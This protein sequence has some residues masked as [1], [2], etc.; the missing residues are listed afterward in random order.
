MKKNAERARSQLCAQIRQLSAFLDHLDTLKKTRAVVVSNAL[1]LA[2][3]D[4]CPLV[5]S[6]YEGSCKSGTGLATAISQ[7]L[8]K[9]GAFKQA[10]AQGESTQKEVIGAIKVRTDHLPDAHHSYTHRT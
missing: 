7:G 8:K 2:A 10:M 6:Q 3:K 5:T 1:A 9:Y 4:C